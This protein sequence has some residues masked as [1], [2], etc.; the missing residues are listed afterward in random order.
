M[1]L[2]AHLAV[3]DAAAFIDFCKRAFGAEELGRHTMPNSTK[4]MHAEIMI[5]KTKMMVNDEFPEKGCSGAASIGGSPVVFNL[6][7]EN[8]DAAA[9]RAA[10]AGAQITMPVADQFWGARYGQLRDPFGNQWAV[11]QP[12]EQVSEE[13]LASRAAKAMR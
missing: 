3:R 9:Q 7:V 13:E 10:D 8:A 4:I 5:G 11:N 12:T 1:E 6:N 2:I